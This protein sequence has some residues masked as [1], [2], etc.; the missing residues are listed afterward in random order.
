MATLLKADGRAVPVTDELTLETMQ[1]L[2][3]GEGGTIEFVFLGRTE[4][5]RQHVLIVD[6][7]GL[8]KLKRVNDAASALY[9]AVNEFATG[10]L[11]GDVLKCV[12]TDMGLTSERYE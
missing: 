5:G 10:P 1:R 7:E 3:A 8:L 11:V 6:E 9:Y 2:V 12:C 4:D